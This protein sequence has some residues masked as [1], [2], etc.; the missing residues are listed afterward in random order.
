M[1]DPPPYETACR[2][3][4]AYQEAQDRADRAWSG[5]GTDPN[6]WTPAYVWGALFGLVLSAFGIHTNRP[7]CIRPPFVTLPGLIFGKR[8]PR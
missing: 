6:K 8:N 4:V 2:A 5:P 7:L 3:V 1:S